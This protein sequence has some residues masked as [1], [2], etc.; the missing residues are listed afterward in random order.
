[1][2]SYRQ[3][4]LVLKSLVIATV[5][6]AAPMAFFRAQYFSLEGRDLLLH[7]LLI[8]A[9]LFSVC[10][11]LPARAM[12]RALVTRE[13]YR[14]RLLI[15]GGHDTAR[16]VAQSLES[17]PLRAFQIVGFVDDYQPVGAPIYGEYVNSGSLESIEAIVQQL[18]V[19][20]ILIAIDD[21]PY[22]RLIHIVDRCLSTGRIVRIYSNLLDVVVNRMNVEFY[23]TVPVIMLSQQLGNNVYRRAKR[24]IDILLSAVGLVLL[25]PVFLLIAVGIKLSSPGP[26][27]FQQ[28]RMG[29]GG[30]PFNFLKFR[31]M[32]I[33]VDDN[34][35]KEFVQGFIAAEKRE[36]EI[37]VFKITKDPRIFR[38]GRFIRKTSLDE[39]P[40]LYNVLR[41]E[42]SLVGPR[43]CLRYEWNVYE[44]W[45]KNRLNVLPGCT[46]LW[47]AIAR[48]SVTFQEM[49]ILDLYYISNLS[50]WLDIRIVLKTFPVIFLGKGGF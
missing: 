15:V 22:E 24:V 2:Q 41:G 13:V 48:S 11:V 32:H 4:V 42:M 25:A 50:P 1:M 39:L 20:E 16:R 18:D 38:F 49:V 45:H 9:L 7:F 3:F 8:N 12:M 46:G 36:D 23:S 40:Q 10:R 35:H 34:N 27:L 31:S 43:P 28:E 6:V 37:P 47:Q 30:V 5:V 17:D 26:V 14:S 19:N 21:A 33:G 44:E 29:K